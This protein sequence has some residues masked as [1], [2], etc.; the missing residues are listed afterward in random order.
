[1]SA[2]TRSTC[3]AA[4]R[5]RPQVLGRLVRGE[6]VTGA[7]VGT[8]GWARIRIEGDGVEGYV[9]SRYLTDARADRLALIGH[10]GLPRKVSQI[11]EA[12][13][14]GRMTNDQS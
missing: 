13:Q 9:A 14:A 8:D 5:P 1:M 3:A 11:T 4:P 10:D 12:A 6:A 7:A 2:P